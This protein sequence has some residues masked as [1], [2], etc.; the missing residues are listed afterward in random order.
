MADEITREQFAA[1]SDDDQRRYLKR[2]QFEMAS[3]E[4]QAQMLS[5]MQGEE[6]AGVDVPLIPTAQAAVP[7]QEEEEG[8]GEKILGGLEAA[9]TAI[10]SVSAAPARAA[11]MAALQGEGL[12]GAAEAFAGQF[13]EDPTLAPTSRQVVQEALPEDIRQTEVGPVSVEDLATVGTELFLD[14]T[15]PVLGGAAKLGKFAKMATTAAGA[16]MLEL[17]S[18]AMA[19]KKQF[20][21]T[22][23]GP[24]ASGIRRHSDV[25]A[26]QLLGPVGFAMSVAYE[27][28]P[29]IKKAVLSGSHSLST[30]G[31][32][33]GLIPGTKESTYALKGL[34]MFAAIQREDHPEDSV[35]R[36]VVIPRNLR[37]EIRQAVTEHQSLSSTK[38][39]SL[40]SQ[41]NRDGELEDI[42]DLL[43][44]KK[45]ARKTY[46]HNPKTPMPANMDAVKERLRGKLSKPQ[47]MQLKTGDASISGV[48]G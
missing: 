23:P 10:E 39:A 40:L 6:Q 33:Q 27:S 2:K 38:K 36:A 17:G 41:I 28:A 5:E 22:L 15:A 3:D 18:I 46:N 25:L 12:G 20:M 30:L 44:E 42:D 21:A 11:T 37:E 29:A 24:V 26:T 14:P 16:K 13:A 48:R 35:D 34:R 31:R 8:I 45:P 4:E 47:K 43:D 19:K 1:M 32:A 9:G 7:G